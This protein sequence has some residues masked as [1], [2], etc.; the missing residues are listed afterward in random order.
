MPAGVARVK[1]T[2]NL[3]ANAVTA[4][5]AVSIVINKNGSTV[6]G[7]GK[8]LVSQT[9][10]QPSLHISTAVLAVVPGDY[11]EVYATCADT[12]ITVS[13][14]NTSFSIQAI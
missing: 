14:V 6:V 11:F 12:S 4:D 3:S 2:A 9:D 10:T 1:L 8:A 5:N 7:G 13:A